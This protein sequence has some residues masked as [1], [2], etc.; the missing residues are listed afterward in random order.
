MAEATAVLLQSMKH[1][2]RNPATVDVLSRS[3]AQQAL[4]RI[5]RERGGGLSRAKVLHA[6]RVDEGLRRLL[7][8]PMPATAAHEG[9]SPAVQSELERRAQELLLSGDVSALLSMPE[10]EA[11]IA[12]LVQVDL[13]RVRV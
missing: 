6:L 10:F 4:R 1:G 9:G 3:I 5:E 8:L 11:F 7:G 2:G 12:Q 13:V